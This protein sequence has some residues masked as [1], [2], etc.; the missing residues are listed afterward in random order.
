MSKT[1]PMIILTAAALFSGVAGAQTRTTPAAT[2][3]VAVK[4]IKTVATK[5]ATAA[6][7]AKAVTT[8]TK[9]VAT[10]P[11]A[12]AVARPAVAPRPAAVRAAPAAANGRMVATTTSTGKHIT[13][14]CSKAGNADKK[15]CK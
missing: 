9:T 4:T 5:P 1:V 11:V 6:A 2:K 12:T 10:R 7:P 13:Y 8:T 3:T 15:A 14:N